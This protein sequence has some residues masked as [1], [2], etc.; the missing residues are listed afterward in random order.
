MAPAQ[1]LCEHCCD[2]C[3]YYQLFYGRIIVGQHLVRA[4]ILY[5]INIRY[6]CTQ[7]TVH[8]P[9]TSSTQGYC[10]TPFCTLCPNY[11]V[12]IDPVSHILPLLNAYCRTVLLCCFAAVLLYCSDDMYIRLQ[13]N[14][15]YLAGPKPPQYNVPGIHRVQVL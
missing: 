9:S 14:T 11:L 13:S 3:I 2:V 6:C 8:V 10:C 5:D 12:I 7:Q 1:L 15:S 4:G